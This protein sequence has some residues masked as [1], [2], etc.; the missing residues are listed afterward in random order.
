MERYTLDQ[1]TTDWITLFEA[2]MDRRISKLYPPL[3]GI[4]INLG[5]GRKMI[6]DTDPLDA[7]HRWWAGDPMPYQDESVSVIFAF[8]F[9]EHLT[10]NEIISVLRECQRVLKVGG[11][12]YTVIPHWSAELAHQDIDHKSFWTEQSWRTLF[13]NPYYDGTV[14][15]DWNLQEVQTL[16]MGLVQRNLVIV[17]QLIR[18]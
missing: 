15:R 2:G 13:L 1:E 5:A 17:S 6:E 7:E 3:P 4:R 16:I 14:P 9:F 12:I 8:H 10:K 11:V 18:V